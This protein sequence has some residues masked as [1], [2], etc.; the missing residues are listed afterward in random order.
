MVTVVSKGASLPDPED[1]G[2]MLLWNVRNYSPNNTAS[3]PEV[4]HLQ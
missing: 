2:K 3:H 1:E 4:L